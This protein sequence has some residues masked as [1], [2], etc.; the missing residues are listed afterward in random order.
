MLIAGL[1]IGFILVFKSRY[2]PL[3]PYERI[4]PPDILTVTHVDL[5]ALR[6][7]EGIEADVRDLDAALIKKLEGLVLEP[8]AARL[9]ALL[10]V[11]DSQKKSMLVLV[12]DQPITLA[13]FTQGWFQEDREEGVP[14]LV[15]RFDPDT[16]WGVDSQGRLLAGPPAV[17]KAALQQD[18]DGTN[19]G[20]AA[21]APY[22]GGPSPAA[23]V[24]SV[25][26]TTKVDWKSRVL[27]ERLKGTRLE[28][29]FFAWIATP[30]SPDLGV[31]FQGKFQAPTDDDAKTCHSAFDRGQVEANRFVEELVGP[32]PLR[33]SWVIPDRD[34][35]WTCEDKE[36][37]A[38]LPLAPRHLR[39]ELGQFISDLVRAREAR[40]ERADAAFRRESNEG[41]HA[42]REGEYE[43]A[44]RSFEKA[45]QILP[46][47]QNTKDQLETAQSE[48]RKKHD[49][50]Q[51]IA[52]ARDLI[53]KH[54]LG[55]AAEALKRAEQLRPQDKDALATVAAEIQQ[56]R[57]DLDTAFRAEMLRG[58]QAFEKERFQ[59]AVT[60]FEKA[61]QN[62]PGDPEAAQQMAI[63]RAELENK[64][65]FD[66]HLAQA[67]TCVADRDPAKAKAALEKARKHRPNDPQLGGVA[68]EIRVLEEEVAFAEYLRQATDAL[69]RDDLAGAREAFQGAARV[70]PAD[71]RPLDG[72]AALAALEL[73]KVQ[74]KEARALF[75]GRKIPAACEAAQKAK[76][77]IATGVIGKGVSGVE[78]LTKALDG[79]IVDLFWELV[80]YLENSAAEFRKAGDRS[81]ADQAFE[82]A[83]K[84]YDAAR[85][86][87][88][89]GLRLLATFGK[90]TPGL[91]AEVTRKEDVLKTQGQNLE[92]ARMTCRGLSSLAAGKAALAEGQDLLA[93]G[94]RT[95]SRLKAA[96]AAFERALQEFEAASQVPEAKS[97]GLLKLARAQ[98]DR[99]EKIFC[100]YDLDFAAKPVPM[101]W[102]QGDNP[103][104]TREQEGRSW[105]QALKASPRALLASPVQEYPS[106]F[107]FEMT[108]ACLTSTGAVLNNFFAHPEYPDTVRVTLVPDTK[109]GTPLTLAIGVDPSPVKDNNYAHLTVGGVRDWIAMDLRKKEP[110]T[111][112]VVCKAGAAT[113]SHAGSTKTLTVPAGSFQQTRIS[114]QNIGTNNLVRGH[115]ALSRIALRALPDQ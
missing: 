87:L 45:L 32:N 43:K 109:K 101:D 38:D 17:V 40:L 41:L 89:A 60:A 72:L 71:K 110:F 30:G 33:L 58:R 29:F 14:I 112:R 106:D 52:E 80:S 69:G 46:D 68:G 7:H 63:A 76:E 49:F 90:S 86:E 39:Q 35:R 50:D 114:V 62:N 51:N 66:K 3:A 28:G 42:L 75:E 84:E 11:G 31:L 37:T 44:A 2:K 53:Q 12:F 96:R 1:T 97:L 94:S 24:W 100:P 59:E 61:H 83:L 103:W 21:L 107:E 13:T 77:T 108:L 82:R 67:R 113:V 55:K 23:L 54:E 99:A 48:S 88:D 64:R 92:Q 56:K 78:K 18:R 104:G 79:E 8:R 9:R 16:V 19:S 25:G 36:V 34:L 102:Y 70:R 73:G 98:L 111:I 57:Q 4:L 85:K 115:V 105:V 47:D 93:K 10:S 26:G 20:A 65:Q 6:G 95:L 15:D 74:C 22:L 5:E 81:L 91:A 27:P